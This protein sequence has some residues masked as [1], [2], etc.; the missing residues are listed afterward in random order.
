MTTTNNPTQKGGMTIQKRCC[1][2]LLIALLGVSLLTGCR[3]AAV[4]YA[5]NLPVRTV[6]P[7]PKA[8]E[9]DASGAVKQLT[10]E[11]AK[12]IALNHAGF[13]AEDVRFLRAEFEI[14]DRVTYYD[15]EFIAERWEYE[16]EIHA[17]TGD[18]LSFDKD[19]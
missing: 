2:A 9:A 10:E 7:V 15:I 17:Q 8:K 19:D 5:S 14:D 3:A 4:E 11:E 6:S 18:V 16:Y 1:A 12:A 13:Q